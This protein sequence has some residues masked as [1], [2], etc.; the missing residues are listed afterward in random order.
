MPLVVE[1]PNE[2]ELKSALGPAFPVWLGVLRHTEATAGPITRVWK[3]S[4]SGIGRMCLLQRKK[5]TLLYL[6][7]DKHELWVAVIL[8]ERAYHLAM[9]SSLPAAIKDQLEA[10]KPYVEGRGIRFAIRALEDLPS[11]VKLL[12]AKTA[13]A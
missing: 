2:A 9:S 1:P 8:G 6:T 4:K 11:V 7:P 13:V 5:R 12:E 3:A 10:A